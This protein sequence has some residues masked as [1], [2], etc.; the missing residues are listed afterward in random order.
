MKRVAGSFRDPSGYVYESEQGLLRA[1]TS[2]YA[3][4]YEALAASGL[5][6]R[7]VDRGLLLPFEEVQDAGTDAWRTLKPTR[8]PFISYPY[9]WSFGQLKDA[10]LATLDIQLAA[11]EKGL[12]LK[13][14]TAYNIQFWQG[15]PV[16]MDHLSFE[17]VRP[18]AWPAYRQFVMHFLAPLALMT[19]VDLRSGL[20]LKNHL[21]GIPLDY[22][23]RM[24]PR[25]TWMNPRLF[26]HL[27]LHARLENKYSDTRSADLKQA[28]TKIRQSS[29]STQT[30]QNLAHSLRA[31]VEAQQPPVVKT[32]WGDYY[33]DTN[34][35]PEAFAFKKD[36]VSRIVA[37]FQPARACDLGANNGEFSRVLAEHAQLVISSDIDPVAVHR[38]YERARSKGETKLVPVLQDICNPS[39]GLGWAG[40]ERSSFL[41][42]AR[43]DFVMG[44]A[45]IHHLC[46]GNNVPLGYVAAVFRRLSP[47]A[48]LEFVP[49]ED[50]QVQRLLSAREDIFP[51]YN[52]EKC[53]EAFRDQYG[54]VEQI[55]IP[56]SCRTLL[57]FSS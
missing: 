14:A 12:W 45:L 53:I 40:E 28:R 33:T 44:L 17:R 16:L 54:S 1:V 55:P 21:D 36:A 52:L 4:E 56:G 41:D 19:N 8:L 20:L 46:I 30:L 32:E 50:S 39:P 23:S 10:A 24:L 3:E 9:E 5:I 11:L 25:A 26:A 2:S 42:R 15:K 29:V 47:V 35:T 22:A 57:V 51:D 37:K 13:D 27:H 7:L 31:A 43:C 6:A 18:G 34:Y 49:K 48:L 38:N